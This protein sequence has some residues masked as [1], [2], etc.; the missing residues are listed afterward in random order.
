MFDKS[1][2][3]QIFFDKKKK[4]KQAIIVAGIG[5]GLTAKAAVAGRGADLSPP[6]AQLATASRA[7]QPDWRSC[8]TITVTRSHFH[9]FLRFW[10]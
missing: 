7:S 3:K 4:E 6:T 1:E 5:S 2:L 10:R 9:S 8:L